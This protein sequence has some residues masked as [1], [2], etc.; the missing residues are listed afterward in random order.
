MWWATQSHVLGLVY[1][2]LFMVVTITYYLG[3]T[4]LYFVVAKNVSFTTIV[5]FVV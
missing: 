4:M 2:I 3:Y 5:I 1:T